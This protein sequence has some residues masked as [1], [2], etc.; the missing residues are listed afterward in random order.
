[1][2]KIENVTKRSMLNIIPEPFKSMTYVKVNAGEVKKITIVAY[3]VYP[4]KDKESHEFLIRKDGSPVT[5]VTAYIGF[6]D[7]TYTTSHGETVINQLV[8]ETGNFSD[9][10]NVYV[11]DRLDCNVKIITTTAKY[12]KG[13]TAKSFPIWAFEPQ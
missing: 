11:Y 6:D 1:M 9:E 5:N 13:P 3:S 4:V 7:G 10:P 2:Q 12:G 8:S